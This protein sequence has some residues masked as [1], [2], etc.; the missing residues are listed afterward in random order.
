MIGMVVFL[1]GVG[2][3]ALVFSLA[4]N[5]FTTPP[6]T[7]LGLNFTG[8]PKKDPTFAVIGTQFAGLLIRIGYLAVMSVVG[9]MVAN[10]GINLY[11][12]A[13]HGVPVTLVAKVDSSPP[14][15]QPLPSEK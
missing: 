15:A 5:L 13:L 8:D 7:A 6:A 4:Y 2:L 11:F 10:K 14:S 12:S 3:L 1:A 9:S